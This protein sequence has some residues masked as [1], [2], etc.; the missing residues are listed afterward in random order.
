MFA[1]NETPC[2]I[3]PDPTPALTHRGSRATAS[4]YE[5]TDIQ[6]DTASQISRAV[7]FTY[8]RGAFGCGLDDQDGDSSADGCDNCPTISNPAQNVCEGD[9]NEDCTVGIGDLIGA[10]SV[11]L[12][13]SPLSR[14]VPADTNDDGDVSTD[15]VL[16]GLRFALDGCFEPVSAPQVFDPVQIDIGHGEGV[17]GAN[18]DIPIVMTSADDASGVRVDILYESVLGEIT[19]PSIDC[20][21]GSALSTAEFYVSA[22]T[23]PLLPAPPGFSRLCVTVLPWSLLAPLPVGLTG[24]V[25]VCTFAVDGNASPGTYDLT[26][27][28]ADVSDMDGYS[29]SVIHTDGTLRVCPGCACQ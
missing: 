17:V 9:C 7:V 23:A 1:S 13:N 26:V 14:C 10:V 28:L 25:A 6:F 5:V 8:G 29:M 2:V 27:G 4:S 15:E 22:G 16:R 12:G 24:E 20:A 21:L 3:S 11:S 19:D 18:V